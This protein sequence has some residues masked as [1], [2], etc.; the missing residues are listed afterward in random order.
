MRQ[1]LV[2]AGHHLKRTVRSPGL[3][4]LLLA[5]PVTIAL[6]EYA[7]FGRTAAA[8]KLPPI[9]VLILDE[10]KTFS[11]SAVPQIFA[12]GPAKDFF[13]VATVADLQTAERMFR[14]GD[15]SA[16]ASRTDSSTAAAPP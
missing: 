2:I 9:K 5:I 6:I 14:R 7:A 3:I 10:D 12:G 8:G 13:E 1:A 4:L 11:S 16:V 15:A